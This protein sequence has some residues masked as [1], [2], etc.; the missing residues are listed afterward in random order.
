MIAPAAMY[1]FT[2]SPPRSIR[3]MSGRSLL[4]S[5]RFSFSDGL[6]VGCWISTLTPVRF[7]ISWA[8][9]LS[10]AAPV[11]LS[12]KVNVIGSDGLSSFAAFALSAAAFVPALDP[13]FAPSLTL[14]LPSP[15]LPHPASR[16]GINAA[17]STTGSTCF[18]FMELT[19]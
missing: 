6:P 19:P 14:A 5:M 16:A 10:K 12:K 8:T 9:G 15:L 4:A 11:F 17:A 13:A 1:L 18:F 7:M 3:M 2:M